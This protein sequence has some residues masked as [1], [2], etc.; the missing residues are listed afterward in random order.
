MPIY[1]VENE[2]FIELEF[3][4]FE[5]E[6]IYEVKNLQRYLSNSIGVIDS[7]LLVIATEFS[8]WEDSRRSIDILCVDSDGNLVA[9]EIKRTQDGAF[10]DLQILRYSSMIAKMKFETAVKT[11]ENFIFKNNLN[12]DAEANLL[13]FLGWSEVQED[14]FAQDVKMILISSNFSVE[15]TT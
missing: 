11:Y 3:T 9:I 8:Q 7:E 2:K 15:L 13:N 12:I 4:T 10:M 1:K 14:D 6:K 5:K